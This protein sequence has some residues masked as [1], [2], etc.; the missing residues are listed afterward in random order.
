[1]APDDAE[2]RPMGVRAAQ[3]NAHYSGF[4]STTGWEL[5]HLDWLRWHGLIWGTP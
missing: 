2:G 4:Q 1:M 5:R 3:A